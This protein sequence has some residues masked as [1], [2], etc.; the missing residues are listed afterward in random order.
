MKHNAAIIADIMENSLKHI[1]VFTTS[2][3]TE[4]SETAENAEPFT[5]KEL[6]NF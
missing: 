2:I 5:A 4:E 6:D 3:S 1:A